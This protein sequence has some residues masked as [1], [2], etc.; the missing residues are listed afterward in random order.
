MATKLAF[1]RLLV[2]LALWIVATQGSSESIAA[3]EPETYQKLTQVLPGGC[4]HTGQFDQ[5]VVLSEIPES[6]NSSGTFIYSCSKGLV[7]STELPTRFSMLY[8]SNDRPVMIDDKGKEQPI[9]RSVQK[10]IGKLLNNLIGGNLEYLKNNFS[11]SKT[12]STYSLTP[13]KNRLRK[14]ILYIDISAISDSTKIILAQ[15]KQKY[16]ITI[17]NTE[18]FEDPF[19]IQCEDRYSALQDACERLLR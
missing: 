19:L 6:I 1:A 17:Y 4:Y 12:S 16:E 10:E 14:Y 7:W 13:K 15:P 3:S 9:A 11:I 2:G 5:T 8:L 18:E